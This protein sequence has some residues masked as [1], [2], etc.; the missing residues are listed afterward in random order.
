M[1]VYTARSTRH[2]VVRINRGE[3]VVEALQD[4][5]A[6]ESIATATVTGHGLVESVR[7]DV[8]DTRS[9]TYGDARGF[10]G[11]IELLSLTGHL[12]AGEKEV[13]VHLHAAIARD[14]DNGL[15]VLGGR[16][17]DANAVAVELTVAVHDDL[18]LAR[19][20]EKDSGLLTWRSAAPVREERKPAREARESRES[21][22]VT[23]PPPPPPRPA[24]TPPP[25]QPAGAKPTLAEVAKQL[26]AMPARRERETTAR[27]DEEDAAIEKGDVLL[28]P[29][30]GEAEV[31]REEDPGLYVIRLARSGAFKTIRVDI[32]EVS[33]RG[34][35]GS[36]TVYELKPRRA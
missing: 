2:L 24:S 30:W 35:R 36:H 27:D 31:I 19:V 28:H 7:I 8:F 11:A 18:A 15:Q 29:T 26:E 23:A 13:D 5:C 1:I 6:R 3:G 9:R 4:L 32:F 12:S 14:T 33:L 20:T 21:R 16:L 22:E 34:A 17:L 10:V 25:A